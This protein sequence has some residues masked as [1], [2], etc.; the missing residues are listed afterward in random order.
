MDSSSNTTKTSNAS[1][2]SN[3]TTNTLTTIRRLIAAANTVIETKRA[4]FACD[5]R[6]A[7][8]KCCSSVM[9]PYDRKTAPTARLFQELKVKK[10]KLRK[11]AEKVQELEEFVGRMGV[12]GQ[13]DGEMEDV[14]G[15]IE[16]V[17]R[18]VKGGGM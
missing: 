18:V 2:D 3:T 5:K 11:D 10:E 7:W 8:K 13:R 12:S 4:D 14:E 1:D 6:E 16:G 17:R 15:K 9:D